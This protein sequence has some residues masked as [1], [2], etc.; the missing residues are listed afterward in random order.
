MSWL[1]KKMQYN[2]SSGLYRLQYFLGSCLRNSTGKGVKEMGERKLK[3]GNP[4]FRPLIREASITV[5]GA[6]QLGNYFN[7]DFSM[8]S[9]QLILQKDT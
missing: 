9:V 3:V 8:C 7:V 5:S 6:N 4:G 1:L 2:I